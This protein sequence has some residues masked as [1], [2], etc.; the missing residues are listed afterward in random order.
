MEC[1]KN[2]NYN[3]EK[4]GQKISG[5]HECCAQTGNEGRFGIYVRKGQ[6]D[7]IRG[8]PVKGCKD[9]NNKFIPKESYEDFAILSKEGYNND[10]DCSNW[11]RAFI[12]LFVVIAMLVFLVALWGLK[13]TQIQ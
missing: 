8:L 11:N 1:V 9:P 6:C 2:P 3:C 12:I 10:C 13:N 4:D 5:D 7:K